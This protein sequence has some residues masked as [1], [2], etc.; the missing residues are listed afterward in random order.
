MK[1]A[2]PETRNGLVLLLPILLG[3]SWVVISG[4]MTRLTILITLIGGLITPLIPSHEPLNPITPL[5][6][7]LNPQLLNPITPLIPT[8]EPLSN[9][10]H[11]TVLPGR[12]SPSRA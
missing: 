8:H 6:T 12:R 9:I 7:T 1:A 3:G 11:I 4:V 5:I 10:L 2:Y